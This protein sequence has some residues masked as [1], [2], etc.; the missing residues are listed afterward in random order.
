M[1]VTVYKLSVQYLIR[2]LLYVQIH[3]Q[4]SLIREANTRQEG[5]KVMAGSQKVLVT[6]ATGNVGSMLVPALLNSGVAVRALVRDESKAQILRDAGVEVVIGDLD[7]PDSLTKAVEGA[8]KIFL[9]TSGG[10]PAGQH[11]L[12]ML[13][14]AVKAGRPH[15]VKLTGYGS[16]KSRIIRNDLAVE[17][18]IVASGL[19][20][21]FVKPTFFMQ[22]VM[23]AAQTV[24][25]DGMIYMPFGEGKVGMI[26]VRD[27]AEAAHAVLTT[28]GH[29]GKGYILTGPESISFHDVARGLSGALGKEVSYVNVPLEASKEA[30]MGMGMPE[31]TVDG[32]MELF[33]EFAINWGDR[34]TSAVEELTGHPARSIEQFANDFA[35]VFGGPVVA[36]TPV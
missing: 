15:V 20:Y 25:S 4:A 29:Y 14:A 13:A 30:M 16:E 8:D 6:G 21:T 26:D 19:P 10:R 28:D 23:M 35:G 33:A 36:A 22:N 5:S 3:R 34:T 7:Q 24:A 12:N 2:Q 11:G 17:K 27:I 31:W 18:E 1:Q 32:Y 9:L